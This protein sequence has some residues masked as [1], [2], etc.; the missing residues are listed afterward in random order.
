METLAKIYKMTNRINGFVYVGQTMLSLDGRI[1]SHLKRMRDEKDIRPLYLDMREHGIDNFDIEII[2]E[3]FERHK[4]I[5]EEHWYKQLL[6]QGLP[7]Y[8]IKQ[9]SKHSPNTKQR[10]A[11][12]RQ[13]RDFDYSSD[14]FKSKLSVKT[15]GENNGMFGKKEDEAL[16]GRLVIA[17]DEQGNAVHRFVSVK[18]ALKFL[19]VKG[20]ISLNNACRTGQKYKGYYWK[21]E[22]VNR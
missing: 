5:V 14:A 11:E 7:M 3:C 20:H 13:N 16:N 10:L 18:V 2:D 22:W 1:E 4:F 17:Y 6:D 9:G 19:N 15:S 21:K 8:D 12:L